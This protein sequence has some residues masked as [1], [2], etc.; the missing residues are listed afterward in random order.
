VNQSKDKERN[1]QV[2]AWNTEKNGIL[3]HRS[4]LHLLQLVYTYRHR[5]LNSQVF[6][7]PFLFNLKL[8]QKSYLA[9]CK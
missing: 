5:S 7:C 3:G 4:T 1:T 8:E 6:F 2:Y 9:S